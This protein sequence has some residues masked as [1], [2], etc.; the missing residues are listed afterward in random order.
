[1]YNPFPLFTPN[2]LGDQL[3][4]AKAKQ[5]FVRQ[6]F[7]RGLSKDVRAAF[8]F[9]GYTGEEKELAE[10]HMKH[11]AG[12]ANAFLYDRS[13]EE[14]VIKL[15]VASMQP[16]GFKIFY[17]GKTKIEWIPPP[18]YEEMIR[19]YLRMKHPAWRTTKGKNKVYSGLYEKL[20]DI[21]LKFNFE[22]QEDWV[23][24]ETIEKQ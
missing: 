15:Q 23:L 21:F 12:D 7:P 11:L 10:E 8:L 2:I 13:V 14:H 5:F 9:R 6:S 1:M 19:H 22:D 20:G 17:V 4:D 18:A 16:K 24:L 3:S